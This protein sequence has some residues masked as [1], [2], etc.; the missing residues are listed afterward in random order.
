MPSVVRSEIPS[1]SGKIQEYE[2]ILCS[3]NGAEYIAEQL[4]SIL[5]QQPAPSR[6]LISDDG[7]T[8]DTIDIVRKI[9]AT[10][11]IPLE[12]I[13]GP[14]RGVV[15]NVFSALPRTRAPYVFL[16]D[17]DDVWLEN[18]AALFTQKMTFSPEPHLIFSD[19]WV[20]QENDERCSFWQLDQLN[21][22]NA[23]YPSLLAF[24]NCVQGASTCV[25]QALIQ[26]IRPHPDIAMHD[27][28]L[29]LVAAG[30]G[31]VS[32]IPEPTLLYR[33]HRG[34]QIGSQSR[35]ARYE[36]LSQKKQRATLVLQQAFAYSRLYASHLRSPERQFFEAYRSAMAKGVLRRLAFL[37]RYRP[38]RKNLLRTMTLWASIAGIHLMEERDNRP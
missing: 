28:W 19:A 8:D 11:T 26:A 10:T 23:S 18:K 27:W 21:P 32:I 20:W 16:A 25:N 35:S 5:N 7:S 15:E 17:Q 37:L 1:T 9:A 3:Y 24:H 34:N 12:L 29:G 31:R 2:V 36:S 30:V 14:G 13:Q 33:Q 38:W 6:I 4:H 22:D